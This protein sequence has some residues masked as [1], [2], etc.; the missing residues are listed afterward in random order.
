MSGAALTAVQDLSV[1]NE[2]YDSAINT[3][4]ERFSRKEIIVYL[5]TSTLFTTAIHVFRTRRTGFSSQ[6][7]AF[8]HYVTV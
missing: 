5:H 8:Q 4:K 3:L 2:N 6:G 7:G 1:T